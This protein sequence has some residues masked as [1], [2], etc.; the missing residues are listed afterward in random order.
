M[1]LPPLAKALFEKFEEDFKYLSELKNPQVDPIFTFKEIE[2]GLSR[3]KDVPY[4]QGKESILISYT[5]PAAS[6][7]KSHNDAKR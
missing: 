6:E 7:K 2:K 3:N 5:F 1:G 4:V